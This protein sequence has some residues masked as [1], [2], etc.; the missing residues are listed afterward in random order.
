MWTSIVCWIICISIAWFWWWNTIINRL[1]LYNTWRKHLPLHAVEMNVN[2]YTAALCRYLCWHLLTTLVFYFW[3]LA[4]ELLSTSSDLYL[5]H[6]CWVASFPWIVRDSIWI[7]QFRRW[8]QALSLCKTCI[9]YI[10]SIASTFIFVM[11]IFV[12]I[13]LLFSSAYLDICII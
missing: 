3:H 10:L 5:N 6:S 13:S 12:M 8:N 9:G 1:F 2:R 7:K 11:F 4:A